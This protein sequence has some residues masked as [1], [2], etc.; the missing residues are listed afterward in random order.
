MS[1]LLPAV[2]PHDCPDGCGLMVKVE[3]G[4]AV[5]MR[6]DAEHPVTQGF[7]CQKV[8]RYVQRIHS[9]K[10]LTTPLIR[11]GSK[12]EGRFREASWQEALDVVEQNYRR[13]IEQDGPQA[14]MPY[15][16]AGH[17]GLVNRSA[18]EAF[19]NKLGASLQG[20][21][22]CGTTASAGFV[23]SLGAGP[24]TDIETAVDSDLILIWGNNTLSTNVHAWPFYEKARKQGARVVSIDPYANQTAKRADEHLMLL[25]GT[26]AALA[27]GLMQVLIAEDMLD[28]AFLAKHALGFE[29][30]KKRT[31]EYPPGRAAGIC[32]LAEEQIV[33]L[34]RAYGRARAP[35]IRTGWG[36]A[37][38]LGGGMAMRSIALLPALVNA[39]AKKGGGILRSSGLSD[40]LNISRFT[41]PDLRT[42]ESRTINMV[43]L[44]DALTRLDDPPVK[45]LHVYLSNP[46]VVAPDSGKVLAGLARED[47]FVSVQEMF[48]T[49]TAKFADVVLPS[50]SCLEMTDLYASY[51]HRHLQ[52]ARQVIPAVGQSRTILSVFQELAARFGFSEDVFKADEEEIIGWLLDSDHP[53]LKGIDLERFWAC[54]PVRA[55]I[56]AN[57]YA[58]GFNTPSGKVEFFSQAMADL[59]LD[60]LPNGE[61][62]LDDGGLERF[63]LRLITPAPQAVHELHF[64]RGGLPGGR[65]RTNGSDAQSGR[66]P[67]PETGR[68]RYG[69]DKKRPGDLPAQAHGDRSG[70]A[71]RGRGRGAVLGREFAGRQGYQPPHQPAPG[72]HGRLLRLPFQPGGGVQGRFLGPVIEQHPL[73]RA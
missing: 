48:L 52:L 29:R 16:Y 45:L 73:I 6:G 26:D 59:G 38:Q 25:P 39:F 46:A 32:G 13:V 70:A 37:R 63:P 41:R 24:S 30:F 42:L 53:G 22:I 20:K 8:S 58:D 4:R 40:T 17:M 28:H 31:A 56:P 11:I 18:G 66:G 43:Q 71:G 23:K 69:G 72:R 34:A 19:F 50:A 12:G 57:P 44:G 64:Q 68:R 14:I 21:T 33:S 35:F 67:G 7:V 36:P 1:Q 55:D 60:P 9:P 15:A 61:P 2:C 27:L 5:S 62:V 49:E 51:G 10:R 54:R 65:C 47:L 3:D